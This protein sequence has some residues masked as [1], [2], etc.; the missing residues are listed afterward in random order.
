MMIQAEIA[1]PPPNVIR[2]GRREKVRF[3]VGVWDVR[4]DGRWNGDALTLT[5][6][7][8]RPRRHRAYE[9]GDIGLWGLRH[10]Y[11]GTHA[12]HF[13]S[14]WSASNKGQ[15]LRIWR[16]ERGK[17]LDSG[18]VHEGNPRQLNR[19]LVTAVRPSRWVEG[20]SPG[21]RLVKVSYAY[22]PKVGLFRRIGWKA[23]K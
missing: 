1:P 16:F 12:R 17:L 11:D 5:L 7:S 20:V 10:A 21:V 15:V 4:V 19:G 23:V 13:V 6:A 2:A 18:F 22:D 3:R 9:T 8:S 14:Y